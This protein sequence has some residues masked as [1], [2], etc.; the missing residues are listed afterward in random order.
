MSGSIDERQLPVARVYAQ[1]LLG[2]A[3]GQGE[4]G[5]IIEQLEQLRSLMDETPALEDFFGTPLVQEETRKVALEKLFRDRAS[6]LL[7]DALQVMNRKG[8]LGLIRALVVA[9]REEYEEL[10]GRVDVRVTTAVPLSDALRQHLRVA[11]SEVTGKEAQ[12]VEMVDQSILGGMILR[13]GDRK[14]D[15]S[16]AKEIRKLSEQM[17]ERAS[18]E[19]QGG[20]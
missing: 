10:E 3:D 6:D 13:I 15:T 8:R 17:V 14:I 9:Y 12:L 20:I 19:L 2:L 11:T 18:R 1:A 16:I 7:V 5:E 4:A